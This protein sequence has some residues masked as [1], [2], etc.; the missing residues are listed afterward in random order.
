MY[1]V[2]FNWGNQVRDHYPECLFVD[3]WAGVDEI[4]SDFSGEP[5]TLK[6]WE[7]NK[8]LMAFNMLA[9]DPEQ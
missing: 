9:F 7:G 4:L 6:V 1:R 2:Q 5:V 8:L 3:T